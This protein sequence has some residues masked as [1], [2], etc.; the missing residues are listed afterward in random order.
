MKRLNPIT[1]IFMITFIALTCF[2]G[3]TLAAE[4]TSTMPDIS[5]GLPIVTSEQ[6]TAKAS[7]IVAAVYKDA[8]E[9]SPMLTLAVITVCGI[10]SIFFQKA[11]QMILWAVVGMLLILWGPQL[12]S[13][14][15][16]YASK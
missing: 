2:T 6:F 9:I 7:R 8:R 11:R 1:I 16:N 12:I 4:S 14:V 15:Q 3:I 5:T 10:L 13:L